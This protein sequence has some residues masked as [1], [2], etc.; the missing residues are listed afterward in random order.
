VAD[1][2]GHD[3]GIK[4]LSLVTVDDVALRQGPVVPRATSPR[5]ARAIAT[6]HAVDWVGVVDGDEVLTGWA[7][8]ADLP[9]GGDTL[10]D[11]ELRPFRSVV[12]GGTTLKAALDLIVTSQTRVAAVLDDDD[13]YKGMVTVNELAEGLA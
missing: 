13:H 8:V 6:E 11:V 2:L 10:D 5:D 12:R 7:Y 4:R 3:R 9:D 1:F